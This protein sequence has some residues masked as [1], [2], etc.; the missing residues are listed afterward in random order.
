MFFYALKSKTMHC[1]ENQYIAMQKQ[2]CIDAYTN[3]STPGRVDRE[4]GCGS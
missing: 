4:S 1:Q 2:V 3:L